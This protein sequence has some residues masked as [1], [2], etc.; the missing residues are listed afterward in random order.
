MLNP[1]RPAHRLPREILMQIFALLWSGK[2]ILFLSH[3]CHH[4]RDIALKTPELWSSFELDD[5]TLVMTVAP[6]S[7]HTSC[8]EIRRLEHLLEFPI[9]AYAR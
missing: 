8:D 7:L 5:F 6:V 1:I 2:R 9:R 4:W 3:V